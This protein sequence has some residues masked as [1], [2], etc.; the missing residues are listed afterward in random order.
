MIRL[1]DSRN[2]VASGKRYVWEWPDA[3][4]TKE[5][6]RIVLDAEI[7]ATKER[8]CYIGFGSLADSGHEACETFN[9]YW[10]YYGWHL[11]ECDDEDPEDRFL[12]GD[13]VVM[14]PDAPA[15]VTHDE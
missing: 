3:T 12:V 2:R 7:A 5:A 13:E 14:E 11:G 4:G 6:W 15:A 8:E 10:A 9:A 1:T